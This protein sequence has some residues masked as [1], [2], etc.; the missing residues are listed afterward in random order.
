VHA[1]DG[2]ATWTGYALISGSWYHGTGE[3]IVNTY[4]LSA[5]G[6]RVGDTFTF[7]PSGVRVRIVG[8]VFLPG[9]GG[10]ELLTSFGTIASVEPRLVPVLYDVELRP[11]TNVQ[12]YANALGTALG[13]DYDVSLNGTDSTFVSLI[14]LVAALTLLLTIVAGLGVLNTVALQIRERAHDH[15]V[16]KA[17]GMTPRQTLAMVIC[18]VTG[19]G[20]VAGLIAIPAGMALHSYVLPVMG[21]AAQTGI[22]ASL[23]DVYHPWELVLLALSGAVIAAAGALG[24]GR[25]H[26]RAGPEDGAEA[27]AGQ[28]EHPR[29]SPTSAASAPASCRRHPGTVT[30]LLQN[31]VTLCP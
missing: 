19:V 1:F 6:K 25:D 16:F 4:L 24:Q 27:E 12:A 7:T 30:M 5:T 31:V 11:G 2:D 17:I 10:A 8:E 28:R 15:G 13:P 23:L 29:Y 9:N 18:S 22:P 3:A 26:S 14:G 20:L 21:H